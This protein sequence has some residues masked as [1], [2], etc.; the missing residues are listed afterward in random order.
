MLKTILRYVACVMMPATVIAAIV[1]IL[2]TQSIYGRIRPSYGGN[3][4]LSKLPYI[5][6]S[7]VAGYTVTITLV[8]AL[9]LLMRRM[10][11]PP[12]G[13][14]AGAWVLM[15]AAQ[16]TFAVLVVSAP[17]ADHISWLAVLPSVA[18]LVGIQ[19]TAVALVHWWLFRRLRKVAPEAVF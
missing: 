6:A 14:F 17:L 15:T 12:I 1:A 5:F 7:T 3:V 8:L 18:V 16:T 2:V 10:R 4:F 13:C 19:T 9:A 11:W